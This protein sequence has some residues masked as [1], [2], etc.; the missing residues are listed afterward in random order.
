MSRCYLHLNN[1]I[2]LTRYA[3]MMGTP[4]GMWPEELELPRREPGM[5]EACGIATAASWKVRLMN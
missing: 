3:S 1:K 2:N 5:R 4:E